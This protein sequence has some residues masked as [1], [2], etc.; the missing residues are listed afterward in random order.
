MA[1]PHEGE[2]RTEAASPRRLQRAREQGQV[3]LSPELATL[4]ALGVGAVMLVVAAPPLAHRLTIN[5]ANILGQSH[6]LEPLAACRAALLVSLSIIA[7]I[8]L[9]VAAGSVAVTL[10]QTGFLLHL[11][12][13]APDLARINPGNGVARL[14]GI[15][16]IAN[17]L[18]SIVK[19]LVT[20]WAAWLAI[21]VVLPLLDRAPL[22]TAA[23]LAEQ[24]ARTVLRLFAAVLVAQAAIALSDL[25]LVHWRHARS[26]RMS[27]QDLREE[28][29]EMEGDP[30]VKGRLKRLRLQRARRRMLAAV[31]KATVVITNP[32]HY[33]V[34]LSYAQ[35]GNG[36]P[37][38]VAKGVD[39]MAARI[40]AVA[41]EY[42]VPVVAN[43]PLARALYPLELDREIPEAFYK[44][45][46]EIIAYVW[47]LRGGMA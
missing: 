40:R 38:I 3:P 41:E 39:A 12:A 46:A 43:P 34:A 32:T 27:R 26:L 15:S 35:G 36:A 6:L 18:K 7:P 31:P 42:R 44:P 4:A 14:F 21:D 5:L 10:G 29:K 17:S 2:D 23:H 8:T 47:R 16:G 24:T 28:A 33:A 13:V 20:G 9:A 25:G 1:E 22:W 45:V 30:Q 19:L 37:R 11:A